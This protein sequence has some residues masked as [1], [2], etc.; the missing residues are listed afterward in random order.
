[1]ESAITIPR[2]GEMDP[3]IAPYAGGVKIEAQGNFTNTKELHLELPAPASAQEGQRVFFMKQAKANFGGQEEDVWETVTSGKVENGRIKSTSPPFIGVTLVGAL[4][5]IA[6]L[7][8]FCFMPIH[9]RAVTGIVQKVNPGQSSTPIPGVR[10]TVTSSAGNRP[11]IIAYTRDDGRF[12][13]ANFA[14]TQ[15]ATVTVEASDSA[16]VSHLG[17]ATPYLNTEPGLIGIQTLFATVNFPADYQGLHPSVLQFEGQ[18]LNL[19][20]G[21]RDT[22]R[23]TGR[24]VTGSRIKVKLTATPVVA[25]F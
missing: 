3:S 13:L 7:P 19:E 10:C 11:S 4:V 2:T 22:L 16:G 12:G 1:P 14:F 21:Q 9:V 5:G 18:M 25:D 23:E 8:L 20:S 17:V 6:L 24:V 15:D